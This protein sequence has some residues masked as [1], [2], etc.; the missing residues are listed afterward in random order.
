MKRSNDSFGPGA[1]RSC[2]FTL[3]PPQWPGLLPWSLLNT[4]DVPLRMGSFSFHGVVLLITHLAI[5]FS[6]RWLV[7]ASPTPGF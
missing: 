7:F 1:L 5:A 3:S 6:C 2:Y 4:A